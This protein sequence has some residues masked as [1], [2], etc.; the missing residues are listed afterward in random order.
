MDL[1]TKWEIIAKR[2]QATYEFEGRYDGYYP[3]DRTLK[4]ICE[5]VE[6]WINNPALKTYFE[7]I[8]ND[9]INEE[10]YEELQKP[11]SERNWPV[12]YDNRGAYPKR[13]ITYLRHQ[14]GADY[15]VYVHDEVEGTYGIMKEVAIDGESTLTLLPTIKQFN[16]E[17]EVG[18]FYIVTFEKEINFG[19]G[20]KYCYDIKEITEE[21]YLRDALYARLRHFSW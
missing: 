8:I 3:V 4:H 18:K 7:P 19:R 14:I 16:E 1:K 9:N 2:E 17:L 20:K 12:R 21:E 15:Y 13:D 5:D 10:F 11:I 6:N